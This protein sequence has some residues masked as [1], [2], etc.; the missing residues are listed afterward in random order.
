MRVVPVEAVPRLMVTY[1]RMSLSSPISQVAISPANFRSCGRHATEAAVWM[2]H[3]LPMRAPSWITAPGPIQQS[4]PITV[5]PA[6]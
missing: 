4:S 2:R 5:S 3:R 6:I 1:S